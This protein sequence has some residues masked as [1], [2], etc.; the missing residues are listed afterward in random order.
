MSL[1]KLLK[2]LL[3]ELDYQIAQENTT[4][5]PFVLNWSFWFLFSSGRQEL[6][7]D[8]LSKILECGFSIL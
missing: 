7:D 1:K 4:V 6:N 3:K 8:A 5:N 2:A